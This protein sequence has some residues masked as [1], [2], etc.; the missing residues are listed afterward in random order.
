M[1]IAISNKTNKLGDIVIILQYYHDLSNGIYVEKLTAKNTLR[2]ILKL[3]NK[4]IEI[5]E[6][7]DNTT[8]VFPSWTCSYPNEFGTMI[9][10]NKEYKKAIDLPTQ[11]QN[12]LTISLSARTKVPWQTTL[13]ENT[14]QEINKYF[15][16]IK[17]YN[18]GDEEL[19]NTINCTNFSIEEKFN[20]L[21]NAAV[22]VGIN[23]GM[24]HLSLMTNSNTYILY[25]KGNSPWFYFP[26]NANVLAAN[27]DNIR[28]IFYQFSTKLFL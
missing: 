6:N 10:K 16:W 28:N 14:I 23:N 17:V 11:Q 22:H 12:F 27:K 1:K 13:F 9:W 7:K 26:R 4:D 24:S 2:F 19:T 15:K 18:L 5:L 3:I 21:K 20:L 25:E 8:E